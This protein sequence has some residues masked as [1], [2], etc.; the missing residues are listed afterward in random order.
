MIQL[1]QIEQ[2]QTFLLEIGVEE[3]PVADIE[4]AVSQLKEGVPAL[5]AQLRLPYGRFE[6]QA[7]PRRLAVIG[8]RVEGRQTD[9]ETLV[10]GPPADRAFDA[11]GKPTPAAIGFA[12]G[13]GV[14]VADLVITEEGDKRYVAALVREE[15]RP[16][17]RVLA[18]ALPD[19]LGG[20]S[21]RAVCVGT[22]AASVSAVPCAG[23][24][25]CLARTSSRLLMPG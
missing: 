23:W 8:H 25:L 24:W 13:K 7:T 16:S 20:S 4:T 12:R 15:G 21:S 3:L 2:P 11:E 5:F 10:K 17:A 22:I 6:I 1:A 19:L 18:E 14:A 9:R